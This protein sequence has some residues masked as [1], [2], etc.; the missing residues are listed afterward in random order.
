MTPLGG[1][2]SRLLHGEDGGDDVLLVSPG[3][4]F[5]LP[6]LNCQKLPRIPHGHNPAVVVPFLALEWLH[7]LSDQI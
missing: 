6:A 3:R 2:T 1:V 7:L 4:V 5:I